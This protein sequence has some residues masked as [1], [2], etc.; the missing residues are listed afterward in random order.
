MERILMK[1]ETLKADTSNALDTLF[2]KKV[3]LEEE[4][5]ENEAQIQYQRG[6]IAALTEAQKVTIE[7]E[8]G[9]AIETAPLPRFSDNSGEKAK[10][11]EVKV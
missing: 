3:Q 7:I 1:L 2:R 8:K 10:I 9:E 4:V 11:P 5:K 6:V